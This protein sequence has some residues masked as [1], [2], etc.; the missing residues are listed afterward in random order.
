[1]GFE[2]RTSGLKGQVLSK[3]DYKIEPKNTKQNKD[4]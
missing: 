3:T 2:P 1:M 4:Y